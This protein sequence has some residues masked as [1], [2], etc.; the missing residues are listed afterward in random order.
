VLVAT[1]STTI[2]WMI[3]ETPGL[4]FLGLGLGPGAQP[5]QADLGSMLDQGREV[6]FTAPHV[7]VVPVRPILEAPHV[8]LLG[9]D[10]AA[11]QARLAE[12]WR[13]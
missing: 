10:R 11:R 1:I 12:L 7:A 8:L 9:L 13:R 5:P 3:I 6:L 2:S 4:S